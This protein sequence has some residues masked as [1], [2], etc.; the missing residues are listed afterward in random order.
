[1]CILLVP[2]I[3]FAQTPNGPPDALPGSCYKRVLIPP[4]WETWEETLPIYIGDNLDQDCVET[5]RIIRSYRHSKWEKQKRQDPDIFG[6]AG[7]YFIWC[8]VEVPAIVDEYDVVR[9]TISCPEFVLETIT[10]NE[11][12]RAGGGVKWAEVL[13]DV[14]ITPTFLGELS[15][16]LIDLGYLPDEALQEDG[17]SQSLEAALSFYQEENGLGV[18]HFTIET[19]EALEI[20]W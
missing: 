19:M 6:E 17:S 4:E 20:N 3:V 9:D 2:S 13:C 10:M 11:M 5:I 18:G 15:T 16:R 8:L 12:I 7:I 1:M 14:W